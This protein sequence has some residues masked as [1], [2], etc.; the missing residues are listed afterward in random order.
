MIDGLSPSRWGISKKHLRVAG[1]REWGG[2][3]RRTGVDLCVCVC[4]CAS[5]GRQDGL[6][7]I[8]PP[9]CVGDKEAGRGRARSAPLRPRGWEKFK[10]PIGEKLRW[11]AA[12]Q[13]SSNTH[14]RRV[15]RMHLAG[16][17]PSVKTPGALSPPSCRYS[18]T[19][20]RCR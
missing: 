3:A 18:N 10:R 2:C 12:K 20:C 5:G 13:Q 7:Q 11:E 16:G 19:V 9:D 14:S 8:A 1:V 4:L 15:S 17:R 6:R